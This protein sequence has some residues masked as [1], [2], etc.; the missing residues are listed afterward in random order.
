MN[1]GPVG[2][3]EYR[4]EKRTCCAMLVVAGIMLGCCVLGWVFG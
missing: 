1:P 4:R 3:D 2:P